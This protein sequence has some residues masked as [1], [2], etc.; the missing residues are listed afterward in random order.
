MAIACFTRVWGRTIEGGFTM[1]I[2]EN[3]CLKNANGNGSFEMCR[4]QSVQSAH[5]FLH[6]PWICLEHRW[7]FNS[8]SAILQHFVANE[9]GGSQM[10]F[11]QKKRHLFLQDRPFP[12]IDGVFNNPH[13]SETP[14]FSAIGLWVINNHPHFELPTGP[15]INDSTT[16]MS[17]RRMALAAA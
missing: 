10:F 11:F 16:Q 12:V 1:G 14:L 7:T 9:F 13:P 17:T 8:S 3:E 15:T 2:C 4:R 5:P 6:P